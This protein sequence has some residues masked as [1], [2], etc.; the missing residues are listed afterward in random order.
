MT[1]ATQ[2]RDMINFHAVTPSME[3][4][5]QKMATKVAEATTP[6]RVW[7]KLRNE[8]LLTLQKAE[9]L[10]AR[11][12]QPGCTAAYEEAIGQINAAKAAL[13]SFDKKN[14]KPS[15]EKVWKEVGRDDPLLQAIFGKT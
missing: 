2:N 8:L 3:W 15:Q 4:V 12:W 9:A 13:R 6:Y 7:L 10:P 1:T 5:Q 11:N 14:P